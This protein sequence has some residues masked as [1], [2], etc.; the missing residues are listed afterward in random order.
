M[1]ALVTPL[2]WQ[3]E[4]CPGNAVG[5]NALVAGEFRRAIRSEARSAGSNAPRS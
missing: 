1:A 5:D 3:M 4:E 2:H